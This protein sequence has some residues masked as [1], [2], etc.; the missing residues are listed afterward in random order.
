MKIRTI[1]LACLVALASTSAVAR[2]PAN[3]VTPMTVNASTREDFEAVAND[4][5]A[6]MTEGG[7][8]EF[9]SKS[10]RE[11]IEDAFR[12]IGLLFQNA[13]SVDA[14]KKEDQVALF[15]QQETIN[16]LLKNR[17][18]DRVVCKRERKTG[19][20]LATTQCM[21]Y[22][23]RERMRRDSQNELNR[24]QKGGATHNG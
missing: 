23:E 5:R 11:S 13:P 15:N 20:N 16:A 19:T 4:V 7:R 3:Q 8:F 6:E 17:D 12:R 18:S 1:A 24:I 22:G 9:L 2:E 14:M 21:T 10:E